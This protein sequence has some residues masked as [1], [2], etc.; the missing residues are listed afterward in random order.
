MIHSVTANQAS[1][2]SVEFGAGLNVVLADRSE[3]ATDKDTRNG[4]GKTTLIDIIDFCLGGSVRRGEGLA[5][6]ALAGWKF[7]LDFSVGKER[8]KATR[9]VDHPGRI[10]VEHQGSEGH[11]SDTLFGESA[12]KQREWNTLLGD[13]L[14]GLG[15]NDD[16]PKYGPTYRSLVSYFLRRGGAAYLES[17]G[18]YPQQQ[19]WNKQ[20]CVAYLLGLNWKNASQWQVLRDKEKAVKTLQKAA[21]AAE[22]LDRGATVG[23]MEATLVLLENRLE[24]ESKALDNFRVHPQYAAIQQEADRLTSELHE[25]TNK[26]V[27]DRRM[28]RRYREAVEEE[29]EPPRVPVARLYEEVGVVFSDAVQRTLAETKQF[30]AQII[31]NR[32]QFLATEIERIER[33]IADRDRRIRR[34]TEERAS[35]LEI[36][37]T[38]GAMQEMTRLQERVVQTREKLERVAASIRQRR[39]LESKKDE[40][41]VQRGDLAQ[42]ARRDHQE[43]RAVWSRAIRLFSDNSEALYEVPGELIIDVDNRGFSYDVEINKSGSDGVDKMKIFCFD[44]ML[45]QSMSEHLGIDFLIH[46]ST[47]FD[48]VDSRQ[49]ARALERANTV[50]G[51]LGKQ[52]ICTFNSDMVPRGDFGSGFDFDRHVKLHLTDGDPSGSLLGFSFNRQ[53]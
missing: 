43:R 44:L 31:E 18:Y 32:R 30:R 24:S 20:V 51:A 48:G 11:P 16:V 8:M 9:G 53:E 37:K 46:D 21:D 34:L 50:A 40:V 49:R 25:T 19:S 28:V 5:I 15:S 17:F 7:T 26:N 39:E 22:E 4:L 2:R 35:H 14:F 12:Y 52:Y 41:R 47:I 38:H 13:R 33:R 42:V 27:L 10:I 3:T 36:L 1:F 23:A 6:D 29:E 45:L